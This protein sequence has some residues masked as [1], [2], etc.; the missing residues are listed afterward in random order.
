MLGT[1]LGALSLAGRA[2]KKNKKR[3]KRG[4]GLVTS[5]AGGPFQT[6]SLPPGGG[7]LRNDDVQVETRIVEENPVTG[8]MRLKPKRR[9]RKR[10]LTCG[11]RADIAFIT[12][13]LG[14]GQAGSNAIATLLARCN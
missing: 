13:I 1:A 3:A 12:G 9:R 7:V 8:E 10:L 6:T 11:D 5:F 4:G 14:K 2:L